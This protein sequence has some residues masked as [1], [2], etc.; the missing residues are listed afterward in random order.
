MVA[1]SP[2]QRPYGCLKAVLIWTPPSSYRHRTTLTMT[3]VL[4]FINAPASSLLRKNNLLALR[5][6]HRANREQYQRRLKHGTTPHRAIL[7]PLASLFAP[8]FLMAK[9]FCSIAL[10]VP[11]A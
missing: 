4:S 6:Q 8:I 2:P 10:T 7:R 11:Q 3:T 9:K 1:F 5:G